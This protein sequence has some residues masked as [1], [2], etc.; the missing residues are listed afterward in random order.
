MKNF[1]KH[2]NFIIVSN[3]YNGSRNNSESREFSF[4]NII[5][6]FR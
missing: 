5:E 1:V 2:L 4:K 3:L 6:F